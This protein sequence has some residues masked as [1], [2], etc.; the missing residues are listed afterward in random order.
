VEASED[1][2][3]TNTM[4]SR[5]YRGIYLGNTFNIQGTHKVFDIR[6]GKVK[7]P[8]TVQRLPMPD[9][10]IAEVNKWGLRSKRDK[11]ARKLE[12]LNRRKEKFDWDNDETEAD[13]LVEDVVIYPG[14]IPAEFP[15]LLFDRGVSNDVVEMEPELSDAQLAL[16]A[17]I[18]ADIVEVNTTGVP[19][20]IDEVIIDDDDDDDGHY[21]LLLDDARFTGVSPGKVASVVMDVEPEAATVEEA[22]DGDEDDDIS[23]EELSALLPAGRIR[24][25]VQ[26]MNIAATNTKSYDGNTNVININIHNDVPRQLSE[27]EQVLHVLGVIMAQ[28]YSIKNGIKEFGE[29]GSESVMKE[30]SGIDNLDTFF[31]VAANSLTKEQKQ[32]ALESLAFITEKRNGDVKTRTCV[33]GS[34]QR[35]EEGYDKN[36]ASSPTVANNNMMVT[37]A[38]D[39]H[40]GRDVAT[41]D[42]PQAFLN[43]NYEGP[44]VIMALRGHLAEMM[45]KV[46]PERYKPF[47]IYTSKGVA[48][49]YV[50]MNKAMYGMLQSSLLFYRK[51]VGEL[52]EYGFK[53]NPYDPCVA[54][55]E[56]EGFQLTFTWHW[57][58]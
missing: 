49:L 53:L 6:S 45:V 10:F 55:M 32:A 43:T 40:E 54:N 31:P 16:A 9:S 34:K 2:T 24:K 8:R 38:I 50:R 13:D 14:E 35:S 46:N 37:C 57:M 52:I 22:E 15:G 5:T 7:K 19:S 58:I 21:P 3:I 30:L 23:I 17:A 41:I 26:R 51:L 42:L 27:D 28:T 48:L 36:A 44:E 25:P 47:L 20:L 18:N 39:A 12:F 11:A 29:R 33:D 1:A 56:I 4:E